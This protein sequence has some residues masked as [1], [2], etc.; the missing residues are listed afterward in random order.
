M[1]GVY[2]NHRNGHTATTL[3]TR[4]VC[5][6]GAEGEQPDDQ[7]ANMAAGFHVRHPDRTIPVFL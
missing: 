2:P 4:W 5:N 6:C 1:N 7:R 3:G